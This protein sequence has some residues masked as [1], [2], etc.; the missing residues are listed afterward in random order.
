[1]DRELICHD[2]V[3]IQKIK[4]EI[5]FYYTKTKYNDYFFA[6]RDC[7]NLRNINKFLFEKGGMEFYKFPLVRPVRFLKP[8][9]SCY[10]KDSLK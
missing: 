5:G 7:T 1:M 6:S 9:R 10:D 2:D 3:S 4:S 8:D